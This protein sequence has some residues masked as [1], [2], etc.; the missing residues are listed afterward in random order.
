MGWGPHAG[1]KNDYEQLSKAAREAW[2][3]REELR[4]HL[5]DS[6]EKGEEGA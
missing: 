1:D 2:L 5:Q 3:H 4:Q 6:K